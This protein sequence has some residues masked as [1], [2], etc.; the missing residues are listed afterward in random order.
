MQEQ[1]ENVVNNSQEYLDVAELEQERVI[2]FE[3]W[4]PDEDVHSDDANGDI[5]AN[6]TK[7]ERM[8]RRIC[9]ISK[10]DNTRYHMYCGFNKF[11]K[12]TFELPSEQDGWYSFDTYTRQRYD[13]EYNN[14]DNSDDDYDD[15]SP[16]PSY[17]EFYNDNKMRETQYISSSI[18][19]P[20]LQCFSINDAIKFDELYSG[21]TE[22][23]TLDNYD[24]GYL[25]FINENKDEVHV[26]GR[27][28]DVICDDVSIA[29][30]E[31]K[32]RFTNLIGKYKPIEI[33]IGTSPYNMMTDFSGGHGDKF[34][35][36]SLLLRIGNLEEHRYLS[37]SGNIYEFYTDEKIT[38]Y[39][40]S[41][42]NNC[43]PY[44]YAESAN[45]VYSIN[46]MRKSPINQHD[47]RIVVGHVSYLDNVTYEPYNYKVIAER[48]SW[49]CKY[50]C[51]PQENTDAI[52]I[53]GPF[54]YKMM[55]NTCADTSLPAV[56]MFEN[57]F[58]GND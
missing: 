43:V 30:Y 11:T 26:Y 36:N 9:L 28:H 13:D 20:S 1:T 52:R 25:V 4:I 34:D 38:K 17:D 24:I 39:V 7:Y 40:S 3:K 51:D 10:T 5:H 23:K 56:Q 19:N 45:W 29:N 53:S 35:G 57:D 50:E 15:K 41:V 2:I 33:F 46:D 27:T 31:R 47:N 58:I 12:M 42:G 22:Y 14:S 37:I 49:A 18:C 16:I 8:L 32:I 21:W 54:T 6:P 44:P 48:D 55:P